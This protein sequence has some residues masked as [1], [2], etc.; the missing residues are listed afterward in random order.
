MRPGAICAEL[1]NTAM[2]EAPVAITHF[3]MLD[4]LGNKVGAD[5]VIGHFKR[6]IAILEVFHMRPIFG[7][8][9][10]PIGESLSR[11]TIGLG[12]IKEIEML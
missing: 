12:G 1:V 2:M 3:Q 7:L 4:L 11:T 9:R 8:E 10:L 5:D 6:I